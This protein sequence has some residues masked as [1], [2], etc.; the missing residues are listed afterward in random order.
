MQYKEC[1]A[2][3]ALGARA[4][5]AVALRRRRGGDGPERPEGRRAGSRQSGCSGAGAAE[6]AAP[7]EHGGGGLRAGAEPGLERA[8]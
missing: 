7:R 3:Q 6:E 8:V 4:G 1:A 2:R 5:C